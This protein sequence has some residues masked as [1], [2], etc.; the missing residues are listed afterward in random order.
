MARVR[1]MISLLLLLALAGGLFL[2]SRHL[3]DRW[4]PFTPIVLTEPPG[5][6]TRMKLR[7][8]AG[9][10]ELC[11]A[12]LAEAG[13]MVSI[14]PDGSAGEDCPLEDTLR[15]P[16]RFEPARPLLTCPMAAAWTL[17]EG[18]V[19]RPAAERHFG[20]DITRVQHL[21][22]L[23]CRNVRGGQRRSQHATANAIDLAAVR[24]ADGRQVSVLR[25]YG[26][27]TPAGAFLREA[28]DGACRIFAAVLGPERDAAH[29]N[30]FHLDLG[31]WSACR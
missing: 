11:R 22:T 13:V 26:R 30:H 6:F 5:P 3:P 4:N 23:A 7:R 17:Y 15:L 14:L 1:R 10:P 9:E 21:G 19:L 16:G 18:Q 2:L 27:D 28:R 31:R 20:A 12:V 24:L 8:L 29:A 25:D